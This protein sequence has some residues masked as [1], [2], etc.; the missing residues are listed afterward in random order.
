MEYH[1]L[2]G[3]KV[4]YM[5]NRSGKLL[6]AITTLLEL[7]TFPV[8]VSIL[9]SKWLHTTQ[10]LSALIALLLLYFPLLLIFVLILYIT[11]AFWW[12]RLEVSEDGLEASS[13]LV[14]IYI[15][16]GAVLRVKI[17]RYDPPS[18][19]V[20]YLSL[21]L[22]QPISN[23][24]SIAEGK[25]RQITV[26]RKVWWFPIVAPS[27]IGTTE[28]KIHNQFLALPCNDWP[29]N[30]FGLYLQQ[31]A[32]EAYRNSLV[33]DSSQPQGSRLSEA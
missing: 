11:T 31:Y 14:K 5:L 8:V 3:A 10:D 32:P 20:S 18:A 1:V 15:P 6:G 9:W 27:V 30:E 25:R 29:N 19:S 26:A 28:W 33:P 17:G 4:T 13:G 21:Q 23:R 7:I 12:M 16:W 24:V 2:S 22:R